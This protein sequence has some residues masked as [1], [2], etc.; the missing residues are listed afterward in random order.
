M[1]Y[2][3]RS[4][5]V[6][7]RHPSHAI[8]RTNKLMLNKLT[9]LRLGS[10]TVSSG[11]YDVEINSTQAVANSANK[12]KMK[13]C[14]HQK[15][16]PTAS[17]GTI[18]GSIYLPSNDLR[19]PG[20]P[21]NELEFPIVAKCIFGS[22]GRGNTLISTLDELNSFLID[23]NLSRYIFE[24]F[25]NFSR[26]YRL[27]VTEQGCFY[28][29]RKM[30]KE[31]TPENQRWF[32]ND[33]NSVWILETN[34]S[35]DRPISWRDIEIAS[36]KALQAVGLDVGAVD[37][38]VQSNRKANGSLRDKTDFIILEINSAPSFG[39]MTA[40]MYRNQIPK[41]VDHKLKFK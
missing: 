17:W 24:K 1:K 23:K 38:K 10:T 20:I 3:K 32:R 35:F 4:L 40:E 28:T 7:T 18:N 31:E 6:L 11:N 13:T 12:L 21:I 30:I 25:Y 36:V 34:E 8:L 33:S 14:F 5:R 19:Y 37:V 39:E 2:Q 27:H 41:I 26:E 16:V 15:E 29:C 9:L 22:R